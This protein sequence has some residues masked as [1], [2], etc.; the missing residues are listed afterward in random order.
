[1]LTPGRLQSVIITYQVITGNYS[2]PDLRLLLVQII[3]YQ[4]ITGNYSM[5]T[6]G[7]LQSVI[8]TYQVI[9]GNYSTFIE[10]ITD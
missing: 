6:P 2:F 9:T 3:T 5:L 10:R 7:R 4:V 8:I 1:M